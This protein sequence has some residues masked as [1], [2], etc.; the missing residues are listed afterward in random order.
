M[1]DGEKEDDEVEGKGV[2][3]VLFHDAEAGVM[4]EVGAGERAGSG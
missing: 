1:E 4:R 2:G 3:S